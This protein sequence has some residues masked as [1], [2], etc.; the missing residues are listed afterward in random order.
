[1]SSIDAMELA[2]HFE[3]QTVRN[4]FNE[5]VMKEYVKEL[6]KQLGKERS[7]NYGIKEPLIH[8][9][10]PLIW[11]DGQCLPI[12]NGPKNDEQDC[13]DSCMRKP[14]CNAINFSEATKDCEHRACPIPIPSPTLKVD[15]YAGYSVTAPRKETASSLCTLDRSCPMKNTRSI[16][17]GIKEL[18]NVLSWVECACACKE[19][20]ECAFW[21]WTYLKNCYLKN[22]EGEELRKQNG[23]YSGS[24]NCCKK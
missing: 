14:S 20:D 13:K 15:G 4:C 17:N 16:G 5:E 24:V 11:S 19:F 3:S 22:K 10:F 21:T 7:D 23:F 2:R 12:G 8:G 1:M 9:P 18:T 6:E